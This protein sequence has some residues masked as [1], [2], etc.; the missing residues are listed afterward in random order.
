METAT[1][2]IVSLPVINPESGRASRTFQYRG[3]VDRIEGGTLIDWKSAGD[4][5]R[6]IRTQ[7]IGFQPYLYALAAE[8]AG[9]TI[10]TIAYRIVTTPSIRFCSKDR[11]HEKKHSPALYEE[12]CIEWLQH[13]GKLVDYPLILNPKRMD[14]ARAYLWECGKRILDNRRYERWLPN[15]NACYA[16]ERCCQYAPLCEALA[17]G[18]G[19]HFLMDQDFEVAQVHQELGG[20]NRDEL[21]YSSTSLLTLCEQKYFWRIEQGLVK[22]SDY[23]EPLWLGGAMHCGLEAYAKSTTKLLRQEVGGFVPV[24]GN[25]AAIIDASEAIAKWVAENPAIGDD[26]HYVDQQAAKARAMVRVAAEKWN[27]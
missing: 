26:A 25:G 24:P 27:I 19:V 11:D 1:E 6:F 9:F 21:T 7:V 23:A 12:R 3:K 15:T 22:K 13:D 17:E 10:D 20:G 5:Q 16:W 8:H 18:S 14:M 2:Q 4:P